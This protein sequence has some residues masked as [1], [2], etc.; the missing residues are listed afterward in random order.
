MKLKSAL[1]AAAVAGIG[2]APATS[3]AALGDS[4]IASGGHIIATFEGSD[5]S[6]DSLLSL[7]GSPLIF[8]NHATA[9]GTTYDFGDFVAGTALDFK[10][11]VVDP[12]NVWHVGPA[13][14]N[15]DSVIHANVI[16]N[17]TELGRT[18]VGFED[19]PGGGDLDYNDHLFSFTNVNPVPEPETY[20]MFMAGLG[21]M[22]F[23]A[24][25]RKNG[26]S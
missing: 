13:S 5:A 23:I 4:L 16:Y 22:G 26:Q 9:V 12:S 3:M 6:F 19:H 18:F 1:I 24:R 25:R 11:T 2:L 15:S 17:Y 7:N 21:L 14:G 8:P 10:L 20:A